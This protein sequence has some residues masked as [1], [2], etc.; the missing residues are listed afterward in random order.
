MPKLCQPC[1]HGH[2]ISGQRSGLVDRAAWRY[3]LH[4]GAAAAISAHRHPAADNLAKGNK[5][6]LNAEIFLRTAGRQ[7]EPGDNFVKDK[8][9]AVPVA[10]SAQ[11]LKKAGRRRDD[12]HVGRD[13]LQDDTG[14]LPRPL[15]KEG[16]HC[17]QTIKL[18]GEGV[19]DDVL[20]YAGGGRMSP[21]QG[22]GTGIDQQAVA[23]PV[24]T[25]FK[26]N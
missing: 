3:L 13:R 17:I 15:V 1:R 6:G 7:T 19:F 14:D 24:L 18:G 22:R 8:Q 2:R 10:K 4:Q 21:G 11:S 20:G 12:A 5:I 23:V 25:A 26:F 16:L 9:R